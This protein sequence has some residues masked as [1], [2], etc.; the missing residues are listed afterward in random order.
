M[1]FAVIAALLA[2]CATSPRSISETARPH[3]E[4]QATAE[5]G[6]EAH[7]AL[8]TRIRVCADEWG[9][10]QVRVVET[11]GVTT[12]DRAVINDMARLPFDG[13]CKQMTVRYQP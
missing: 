6:A 12:F 5:M 7:L 9:D 8:E 11:S 13:S 3:G 10:P 4:L 2:A 1:K